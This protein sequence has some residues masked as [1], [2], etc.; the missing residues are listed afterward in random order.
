MPLLLV[1][2]VLWWMLPSGA[3]VWLSPRLP[4]WS[5]GMATPP[6]QG[7]GRSIGE[8]MV[9]GSSATSGAVEFIGAAVG[10]QGARVTDASMTKEMGLQVLP[11]PVFLWLRLLLHPGSL[12]HVCHLSWVLWDCKLSLGSPTLLSP[13]SASSVFPVHPSLDVLMCGILWCVLVC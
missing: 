10:G 5:P 11:F 6:P 7:E 9:T 2:L 8:A 12:S 1:L 4:L 3:L 13:S